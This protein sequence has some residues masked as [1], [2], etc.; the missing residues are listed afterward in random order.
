M[1]VFGA[2]GGF[3]GESERWT[4]YPVARSAAI[5]TSGGAAS[6]GTTASAARLP[7][8]NAADMAASVG[9][10]QSAATMSVLLHVSVAGSRG[11]IVVLAGPRWA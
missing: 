3:G 7:S 6:A 10:M 11:E 4:A 1:Q 5:F 9:R 2:G 8:W